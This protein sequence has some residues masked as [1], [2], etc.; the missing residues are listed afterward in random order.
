VE[1]WCS[2]DYKIVYITFAVRAAL[3]SLR[4]TATSNRQYRRSV[5]TTARRTVKEFRAG[6][7]FEP[8]PFASC[9]IAGLKRNSSL[10]VLG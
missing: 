5:F 6:R 4:S 1:A 8:L 3:A 10:P 7:C 9:A 2:D